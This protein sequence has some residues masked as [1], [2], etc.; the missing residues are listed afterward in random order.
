M[1][2]ISADIYVSGGRY[3]V[4]GEH[5]YWTVGFVGDGF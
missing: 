5:E 1:N 2:A 3:T 4:F